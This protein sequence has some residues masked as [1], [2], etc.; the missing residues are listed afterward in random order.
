MTLDLRCRRV[1]IT[2]YGHLTVFES[3]CLV[4]FQRFGY[5]LVHQRAEFL[6]G[7]AYA[8]EHV[9]VIEYRMGFAVDLMVCSKDGGLNLIV[10]ARP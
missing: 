3:L 8:D 5:A 4:T 1:T 7:A 6:P 9:L 10:M 2:I